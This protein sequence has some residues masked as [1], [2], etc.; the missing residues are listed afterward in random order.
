VLAISFL[1]LLMTLHTVIVYGSDMDTLRNCLRSVAAQGLQTRVTLVNNC[2][3]TF[4]QHIVDEFSEP[5]LSIDVIH[6]TRRRGFSANNNAAIRLKVDS[7]Y[8]VLLL[9]DDT[10]LHERTL[11]EMLAIIEADP[12]IGA[13]GPRLLNPDGTVQWEQMPF[14]QGLPGFIQ[15]LVGNYLALRVMW[16]TKAPFWLV[17][18]CLLV[19]RSALES[20]GALDEGFDPGYQEDMDFCWRLH[21][22]DWKLALASHAHVTHFGGRSFGTF[23]DSRH[24]LIYRNLFRYAGKWMPSWQRFVLRSVWLL[25]VT[26]RLIVT[27][28]APRRANPKVSYTSSWKALI[29]D[30]LLKSHTNH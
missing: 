5:R 23:S 30:F 29:K 26:M 8:Y 4:D 28:F 21:R 16:A 27:P 15:G 13:V 24:R 10:I 1:H 3:D 20:V 6:Q 25:G 18:A 9:N 17:G 2:N 14:A 12:R 7:A 22:T 19:R 11:A